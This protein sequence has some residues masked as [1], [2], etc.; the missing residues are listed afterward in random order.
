MELKELHTL[1][2]TDNSLASLPMNFYLMSDSL[3]TAHR[4]QKMHKHG[5]WL[6]KNPLHTPPQQVWKTDNPHNIYNYMKKLQV[7][8]SNCCKYSRCHFEITILYKPLTNLKIK[9]IASKTKQEIENY[10]HFLN[11]I[12]LPWQQL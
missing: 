2:L 10:C 6:H 4:Y 5:L 7:F 3:T 9:A 1:D 8:H 11:T 12:V